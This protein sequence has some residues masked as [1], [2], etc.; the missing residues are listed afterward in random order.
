[1]GICSPMHTQAKAAMRLPTS[2]RAAGKLP[3]PACLVEGTA[4]WISERPAR[5]AARAPAEF[6][7]TCLLALGRRLRTPMLW[8]RDR[9]RQVQGP[10]L[11]LNGPLPSSAHCSRDH[12]K[13]TPVKGACE[14]GGPCMRPAHWD[15]A[16]TTISPAQGAAA[17]VMSSQCDTN[18]ALDLQ[19]AVGRGRSLLSTGL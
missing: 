8:F 9:S 12:A 17:S 16:W 13:D 6:T 19:C 11:L 14:Q 4:G 15:S 2:G 7:T 10:L 1:M 18:A 3:V 5:K